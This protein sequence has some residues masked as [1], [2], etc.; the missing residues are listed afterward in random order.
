[1]STSSK[2]VARR[3]NEFDFVIGQDK[4]EDL[5]IKCAPAE[6]FYYFYNKSQNQLIK[7]F[8]LASRPQVTYVCKVTL[9]KKGDKFT[10][11]LSLSI[12]DNTG[13]I[14]RS[15][16]PAEEGQLQETKANVSLEE[17]HESFW[18]LISF[19]QNLRD[20][21]VPKEKFSLISSQENDIISALQKRGTP[22]LISII[23]Q[24]SK[25]SGLSLSHEDVN[26][27]LKRRERLADFEE[28]LKTHPTDERWWG[29]FF[30]R[31]KWIFGYGLNYQILK[32]EQS[33]PYYGGTAVSGRGGQKG[34]HLAASLGD[35]RFTVLVE[36]KTPGTQLI[37]GP[38][39]IR[40]GAWSLSK[41]LIDALSQI[42]AN[43]ST[44]NK[45][46]ADQPD[47][48]DRFEKQ[49]IYTVEPKGIIVLGSLSEVA[50]E[51]SKR[52][53]F[54]RFRK[55]IHGIDILTFDELYQ[56]AKFIAEQK[57]AY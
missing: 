13:R 32:Q 57:D 56:R 1:M 25:T 47:N 48:R 34:D 24:L 6:T 43:I 15:S 18:S 21:D 26:Q 45:S 37:Q 50:N 38:R 17:C 51:R 36:I 2:I 11:R 9:I 28:G 46:G 4:F 42:S 22:S 19:L 5:Q 52:E 49:G 55:A 12:R 14:K 53:T 41:D 3:S 33:Q 23:K 31:N 39:E 54:E 16:L 35:V 29:L 30:E 20:I 44:W 40:S 7:Q 27:L 10:P 8:I